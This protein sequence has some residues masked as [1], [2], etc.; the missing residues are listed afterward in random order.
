M[1]KLIFLMLLIA[2]ISCSYSSMTFKIMKE[3]VDEDNGKFGD[4]G[5]SKIGAF[6][7]KYFGNENIV[8]N[9]VG[10]DSA[11]SVLMEEGKI[12][13]VNKDTSEGTVEVNFK[14]EELFIDLI[15]GEANPKEAFENKDIT[16]Y[17]LTLGNKIKYSF[18]RVFLNLL[19]KFA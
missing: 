1:K 2:L 14:S 17:G 3:M 6:I 8:I 15:K 4:F 12:K 7:I 18:V 13:E 16:F 9:F 10:D 19:L 11:F 5:D